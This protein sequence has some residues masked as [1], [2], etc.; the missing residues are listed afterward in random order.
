MKKISFA[1]GAVIALVL[2][3]AL[4]SVGVTTRASVSADVA[5]MHAV[6]PNGA[7]VAVSTAA[8]SNA[9]DVRP[10]RRAL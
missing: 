10:L 3:E 7:L 8:T 1:L 6:L 2:F 5:S 4:G 9:Q